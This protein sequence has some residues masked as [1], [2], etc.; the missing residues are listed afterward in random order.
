MFRVL[1]SGL[2]I[3]W[4]AMA[5]WFLWPFCGTLAA[6]LLWFTVWSFI[7]YKMPKAKQVKA[8]READRQTILAL[9]SQLCD[10]LNEMV[11]AQKAEKTM[12]DVLEE[13]RSSHRNLN[14]RANSALG[15]K[16]G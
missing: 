2:L 8:M 4:D 12:A 7:E 1:S 9:K 3:G 6:L 14:A 15:G 5:F 10:T 11:R 16:S 13:M